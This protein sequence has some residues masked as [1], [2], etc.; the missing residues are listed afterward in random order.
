MIPALNGAT[1]LYAILGDPIEQVRSPQVF[2]PMFRARG[3]NAVMLPLHVRPPDLAAVVGA[4]KLCP[5]L[6]GLIFTV[7]HK[8][9]AIPLIEEVGATGRRVGAI[10]AA[11]RQ[12]DG[13]WIADMFDGRGFV[14]GCRAQGHEPAGRRVLIVGAGGAGSAV[15]DALAEIGVARLTLFDVDQAKARRVVEAL[16]RAYPGLTA[17][18]GPPVPDRH[19]MIVNAT[20]LGMAAD[21]ALPVET[22]L[23]RPDMLVCDVVM[24]PEITPFLAAARAR[25]C[26]IQ[27]GRHMLDGQAQ[28]VAA[29]FG[30]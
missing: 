4:L 29:F 26:A 18:L 15:A 9:A 6:D 10:N 23:L 25:G 27:P 30:V 16:A 1:R 7:P 5:N 3:R 11:R 14:R 12:A 21:D 8:A 20:P 28:A 17:E 22:K 2:N 19:D 13:R 24:K